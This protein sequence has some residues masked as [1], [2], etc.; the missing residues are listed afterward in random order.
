MIYNVDYP[1][2][3]RQWVLKL[4]SI[5]RESSETKPLSSVLTSFD[6]ASATTVIFYINWC[7]IMPCCIIIPC[8]VLHKR[9]FRYCP[10]LSN[11]TFISRQLLTKEELWLFTRY[12]EWF[13]VYQGTQDSHD[14]MNIYIYIYMLPFN[15]NFWNTSHKYLIISRF[16]SAVYPTWNNILASI[17]IPTQNWAI[18]MKIFRRMLTGLKYILKFRIIR[19]TKPMAVA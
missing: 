16:G 8:T 1:D 11:I 18:R 13:S 19:S 12:P 9:V 17:I 3:V 5:C 10:Q 15:L 2:I 14:I 7:D 6:A 4:S